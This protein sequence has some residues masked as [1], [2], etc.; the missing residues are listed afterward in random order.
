MLQGLQLQPCFDSPLLQLVQGCP[1]LLWLREAAGEV[2]RACEEAA[3][4]AVSLRP[5][6][7]HRPLRFQRSLQRQTRQRPQQQPLA[8]MGPIHPRLRS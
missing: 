2:G 8:R 3:V 4:E 1:R 5:R 6:D 7:S